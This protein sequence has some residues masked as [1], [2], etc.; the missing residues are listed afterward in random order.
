MFLRVFNDKSIL[1]N[2]YG[3]FLDKLAFLLSFKKKFFTFIFI[4]CLF[5]VK[6]HVIK[7]NES[8]IKNKT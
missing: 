7:T 1:F 8:I 6:K 4:I 2:H 3:N 5:Y